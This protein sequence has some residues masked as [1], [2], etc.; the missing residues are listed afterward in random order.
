MQIRICKGLESHSMQRGRAA[1]APGLWSHVD[2]R[3]R[4]VFG[5][6]LVGRCLPRKCL[7]S[8]D[9][10][11][12]SGGPSK[13][14]LRPGAG[15]G[16]AAGAGAGPGGAGRWVGGVERGAGPAGPAG[17]SAGW[18]GGAGLTGGG[19]GARAS[20]GPAGSALLCRR[21]RTCRGA[22]ST[23][24]SL[25]GFLGFSYCWS[26]GCD[27]LVTKLE[28]PSW[29]SVVIVFPLLER[30]ILSFFFSKRTNRKIWRPLN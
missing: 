19:C 23:R 5:P 6:G 25:P 27:S 16:G 9:S 14:A 21:R 30:P 15:A 17:G 10:C 26:E 12:H 8:V 18:A 24:V 11:W 28:E 4:P 22:S 3:P 2:A 7:S 20:W 13:M 1:R 29:A